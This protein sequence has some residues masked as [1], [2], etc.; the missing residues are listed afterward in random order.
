MGMVATWH[1]NPSPYSIYFSRTS[2][3]W[4]ALSPRC[5]PRAY[6]EECAPLSVCC[7][8]LPASPIRAMLNRCRMLQ[9]AA[10]ST[11]CSH[12]STQL[13]ITTDRVMYRFGLYTQHLASL[14][15]TFSDS[16]I[17]RLN[18]DSPDGSPV[19]GHVAV[20]LNVGCHLLEVTLS[21]KHGAPSATSIALQY[22]Q[23]YPLVNTDVAGHKGLAILPQARPLSAASLDRS[24]NSP[25]EL[26]T[27][28][29]CIT[30]EPVCSPGIVSVSIAYNNV[31]CF[32]SSTV[33]PPCCSHKC[34]R[35][36]RAML[37]V[38]HCS[39]TRSSQTCGQLWALRTF[40]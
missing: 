28:A 1:P 22:Q 26:M 16:S 37:T 27:T 5:D 21:H 35:R 14:T 15:I 10:S 2:L 34:T 38:G 4:E 11:Q 17:K 18:V 24:D 25:A 20:W 39:R 31:V 36:H 9:E 8:L 30:V 3:L 6:M 29:E 12:F 23:L 40:A 32:S 19:N 7:C 13:C 33:H